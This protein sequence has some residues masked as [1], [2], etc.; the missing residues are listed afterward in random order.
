MINFILV[1]SSAS[2]TPCRFVIRVLFSAFLCAAD[3]LSPEPGI[4]FLKILMEHITILKI[5]LIEK[6]TGSILFLAP[7]R[8]SLPDMTWPSMKPVIWLLPI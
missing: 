8:A 4:I 2:S 5:R 6:K 7:F 1:T 3:Q